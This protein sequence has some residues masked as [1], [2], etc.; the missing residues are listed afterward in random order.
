MPRG[1]SRPL[2]FTKFSPVAQGDV[3]FWLL[4]GVVLGLVVH[5]ALTK[6]VEHDVVSARFLR[7]R[8]LGYPDNPQPLHGRKATHAR[9]T[10]PCRGKRLYRAAS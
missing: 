10:I 8:G 2:L 3:L 9:E 5:I 1:L 7:V 6:G 4:K